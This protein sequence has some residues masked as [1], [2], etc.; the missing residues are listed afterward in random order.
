MVDPKDIAR[1]QRRQRGRLAAIQGMQA[2]EVVGMALRR[3]GLRMV[4]PIETGY[5]LV[6]RD[7]RVVGGKPK[8]KV[9]GDWTAIVPYT[10]RSV[11]CEAKKRQDDVLSLS[12][13]E[14]H[15]LQALN[16]HHALGGLS[17]VGWRNSA[18]IIEILR[19]PIAG[20]EDG[21]PLHAGDE[22]TIAARWEGL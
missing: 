5:D 4:E 13:F 21:A 1:I 11:R 16:E 8:R 2:Q 9:H 14:P 22:R 7:G 17:L 19:W 6:R 20:W 18:T 15:Q 10:G 12:D 3:L